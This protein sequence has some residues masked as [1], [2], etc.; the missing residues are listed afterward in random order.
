MKIHVPPE[1]FIYCHFPLKILSFITDYQFVK[2]TTKI[3][4]NQ[5]V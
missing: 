4:T 3:K 1:I 2:H 5:K